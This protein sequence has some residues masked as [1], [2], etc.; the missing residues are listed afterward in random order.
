MT[1]SMKQY[2]AIKLVLR[3]GYVH[4]GYVCEFECYTEKRG[5]TTEVGL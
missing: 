3:S 2:F 5:G 1:L 4:N